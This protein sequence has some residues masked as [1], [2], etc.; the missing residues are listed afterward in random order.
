MR[1]YEYVIINWKETDHLSLQ[2][3]TT[4]GAIFC[5]NCNNVQSPAYQ[6]HQINITVTIKDKTNYFGSKVLFLITRKK[7]I[8]MKAIQKW[9]FINEL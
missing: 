1:I 6:T 2:L 4:T 3:I 5:C 9:A 8:R 7:K